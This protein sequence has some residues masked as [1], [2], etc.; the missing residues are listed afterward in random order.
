MRKR[1]KLRSL[2]Q[3]PLERSRRPRRL[4]PRLNKRDWSRRQLKLSRRELKRRLLPPLKLLRLKRRD[5]L[6]RLMPLKLLPSKL[7]RIKRK[8]RLK[9]R[10]LRKNLLLPKR[11]K[12]KLLLKKKLTRRPRLRK[13]TKPSLIFG[14]LSTALPR[15]KRGLLKMQVYHGGIWGHCKKRLKNKNLSLHKVLEKS[16]ICT[17]PCWKVAEATGWEQAGLH[18]KCLL[19]Q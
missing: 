4:L 8:K 11:L 17:K 16:Q 5:W 7:K 13:K 2:R 6:R 1:R 19:L 9:P 15:A 12:K 14:V 18:N 3:L 10:K